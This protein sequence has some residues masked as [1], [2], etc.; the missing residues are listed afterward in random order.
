MPRPTKCRKIDYRPETTFFKPAGIPVHDLEVVT[1]SLDELEAL[2]LGDYEGLY[3][4]DAARKM[5][6]SRQTFGNII[7]A[8]R[9]KTAD[10]LINGK[11]LKIEGGT[12]TPV[13]RSFTCLDCM[14]NWKIET[15]TGHPGKCPTCGSE[16]I[17]RSDRGHCNNIH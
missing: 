15:G 8:A 7:E 9:K 10:A 5:E 16:S 1:L 12:V 13:E 14:N 6:I 2:R 11:A 3:H 17:K 4:E